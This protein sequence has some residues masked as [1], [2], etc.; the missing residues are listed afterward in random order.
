MAT[1]TPSLP[2]T[3]VTEDCAVSPDQ[4]DECSVCKDEFGQELTVFFNPSVSG[5]T[6]R[7]RIL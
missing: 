1:S 6:V 3:G 7:S 5:W 4:K 2:N